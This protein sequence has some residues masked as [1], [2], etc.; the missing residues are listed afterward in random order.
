[1][2][3]ISKKNQKGCVYFFKHIGLN[4]IK[5][6][7]TLNPSPI[8]RFNSFKTYA[9]HGSQLVG[10]IQTEN[11]LQLERDLHDKFSEFRLNGEWFNVSEDVIDEVIRVHSAI[12]DVKHKSLFQEEYAKRIHRN[13]LK[14]SDFQERIY[15]LFNEMF[16]TSSMSTAE[17]IVY[18]QLQLAKLFGVQRSDIRIFLEREGIKRKI[19]KIKG[20]VYNGYLLK[21][22]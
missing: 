12:E 14:K 9:P 16:T 10:F 8:S 3:V 17:P 11:P 18:S 20:V 13:S 19:Y 1:M 6:G 15:S 2:D 4:P 22:K 5:I 21:R 7:F